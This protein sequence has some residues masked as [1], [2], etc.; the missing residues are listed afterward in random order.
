[1]ILMIFSIIT[2]FKTINK[3]LII[4]LNP[5]YHQDSKKLNQMILILFNF[6]QIILHIFI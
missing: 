3:I 1:M 4:L 2:M 5:L 6:S